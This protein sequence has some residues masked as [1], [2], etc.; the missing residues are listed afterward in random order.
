VSGHGF[1]RADEAPKLTN[2]ALPKAG[3]ERPKG[4]LFLKTN[5]F[6][7]RGG[8]KAPEVFENFTSH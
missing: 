8:V 4:G 5:A 6:Q 3:A 2:S 7:E 1:I